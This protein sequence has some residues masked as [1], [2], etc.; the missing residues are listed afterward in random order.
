MKVLAEV[1]GG[2]FALDVWRPDNH[3]SFTLAS[4]V[5]FTPKVET[6]TIFLL[7]ASPPVQFQAGDLIGFHLVDNVADFQVGWTPAPSGGLTMSSTQ[8]GDTPV[9]T[10]PGGSWMVLDSTWPILFLSTSD[11]GMCYVKIQYSIC[12]FVSI[13]TCHA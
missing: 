11:T 8:G 2:V 10:F 13:L 5:E 9:T 6:R 4:S 3:S 1:H 7:D 12:P